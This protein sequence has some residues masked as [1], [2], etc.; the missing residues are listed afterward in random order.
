MLRFLFFELLL[1]VTHRKLSEV[2]RPYGW[3]LDLEK[4]SPEKPK[5]QVE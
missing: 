2:L 1:K 5:K 3:R 4:V